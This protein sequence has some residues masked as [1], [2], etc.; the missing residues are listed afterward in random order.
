MK[1]ILRYAEY[2]D[3]LINLSVYLHIHTSL[4]EQIPNAVVNIKS[5]I[6]F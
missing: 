1:K 2:Q 3:Y 4:Q 5:D 6:Q